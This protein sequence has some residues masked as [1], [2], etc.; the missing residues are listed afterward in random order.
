[1]T[2]AQAQQNRSIPGPVL[3]QIITAKAGDVVTAGSFVI[4]IDAVKPPP[5]GIV[6]AALPGGQQSLARTIFEE[7]QQEARG[8][9][10]DQIKPKTNLALARQAIGA[11]DKATA[12]AAPGSAPSGSAA[13]A[14]KAK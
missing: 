7:T 1:M 12:P 5:A 9:A 4:K 10:K 14:G 3:Q 2:R 6:A 13:P 8:W 11:T